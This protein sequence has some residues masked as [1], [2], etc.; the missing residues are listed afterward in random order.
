M[1]NTSK[2]PHPHAPARRPR[3]VPEHQP[4]YPSVLEPADH[5]ASPP[6]GDRRGFLGHAALGAAGLAG[7]LLS[8]GLLSS[9]A[10]AWARGRR[11]P[12]PR[13]RPLRAK[14][15]Y[16][17]SY[18][19]RYGNYALL[20][21]MVETHD[22]RLVAF[23]RD[24]RERAAL[25]RIVRRVLAAHTCADLLNARRL[26]RLRSAVA[27]AVRGQYRARTGRRTPL[28][29]VILAVGV[30]SSGCDG[31]CPMPT[32]ICRPPRP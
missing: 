31:D 5:A 30:P 20:R 1:P 16:G 24:R 14:L 27:K 22:P 8:G 21:A 29:V 18:T 23:V 17:G 11:R 6:D 26:A 10:Q 28:P 25:A 3:P 2:R 9:A 4:A 7:A 32:P 12:R 13:P 19:F 15:P